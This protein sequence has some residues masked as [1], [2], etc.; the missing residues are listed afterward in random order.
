LAEI[1]VT[2]TY[3][4]HTHH[5]LSSSSSSVAFNSHDIQQSPADIQKTCRQALRRR[6]VYS[7]GLARYVQQPD[8]A[9][10]QAKLPKSRPLGTT[11]INRARLPTTRLCWPDCPLRSKR[12]G[13]TF[14]RFDCGNGDGR[15]S[16]ICTG[17]PCGLFWWGCGGPETCLSDYSVGG[18]MVS[19]RRL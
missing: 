7:P 4:T 11:L 19:R 6:W 13:C 18:L 12:P 15:Y 17:S 8:G 14:P 9:A 1:D 16:S 5:S 3:T 10:E 2:I